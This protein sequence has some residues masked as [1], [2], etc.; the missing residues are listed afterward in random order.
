MPGPTEAA[1]AAV[2]RH[3]AQKQQLQLAIY[4][5]MSV[6]HWQQRELA[7]ALGVSQ[8]TVSSMLGRAGNPRLSSLLKI[9]DVLGLQLLLKPAKIKK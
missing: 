4:Q 6:R 9:A 3:N 5:A 8:A 2:R 7:E 1:E